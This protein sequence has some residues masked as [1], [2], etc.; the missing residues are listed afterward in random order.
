MDYWKKESK[1]AKRY[2]IL[3]GKVFEHNTDYKLVTEEGII[4]DYDCKLV[5]GSV[6]KTIECKINAGVSSS[7]YKFPTVC[8]E[9]SE[10]E[11]QSHWI[12]APFDLMAYYNKSDDT[13][14]WYEGKK[15]RQYALDNK[16]RA[17]WSVSH[18]RTKN[19]TMPWCYTKAGWVRSMKINPETYEVIE[20]YRSEGDYYG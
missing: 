10:W 20:I 5:S 17:K 3:V 4:K 1:A 16:H 6:E 9:I 7:G 11:K 8:V 15:I 13:I 14:H 12:T 2:E 18:G 19:I